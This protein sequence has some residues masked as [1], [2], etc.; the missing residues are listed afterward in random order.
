MAPLDDDGDE[1]NDCSD[2]DSD[3]D[4]DHSDHGD[5][6]PFSNPPPGHRLLTHGYNSFEDLVAELNDYYAQARFSVIKLRSVNLVKGFG[7]SRVDFGCARGKI[8]RSEAHSRRIST[9]KVGYTWEGSAKAL[10][11]NS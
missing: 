8:R 10:L 6:L 7:Y 11:V 4:S 9:V 1:W 3:C 5:V 2:G